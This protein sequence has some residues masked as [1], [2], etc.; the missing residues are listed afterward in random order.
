MIS[1]PRVHLR[2]FASRMS[3]AYY[4]PMPV[5]IQ[6]YGLTANQTKLNPAVELQSVE[7]AQ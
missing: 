3:R 2:N 6:E 1:N 7:L 4:T 5:R